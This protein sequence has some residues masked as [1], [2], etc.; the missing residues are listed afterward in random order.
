MKFDAVTD[1]VLIAILELVAEHQDPSLTAKVGQ[2]VVGPASS[3]AVVA[4]LN[5]EADRMSKTT[6]QGL[7]EPQTGLQQ[8]APASQDA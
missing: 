2:L 8:L 4:T 5:A 3:L 1:P 6:R 7:D